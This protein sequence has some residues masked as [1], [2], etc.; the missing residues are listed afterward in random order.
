MNAPSAAPA[1]R[2]VSLDLFRGIIMFLLVAEGTRLYA[3]LSDLGAP[4]SWFAAVMGQ[5]HHHPWNGLWFWDLIQPGFMFIVGVAMAYSLS[6]RRE[7]GDTWNATFRHILYRC[8][9]LLLFGVGLHCGYS[10][11][12]VWELWNV[13]SQLSF[14][15]LVAFLLFRLPV[16]IQFAASIGL[17][18]LTEILYRFAAPAGFDQPFVQGENFGSW[19]D[20][21]LMGKINGGGWVAVNALPTAVH[22]IWGVL[23]GLLLRGGREHRE[24]LQW[25]VAAGI[26]ALVVGYGM[27]FAGITPIIKRIAT[28][29]FV[30]A[31]GGWV[32]LFLAAAYWLVDVRGVRRIVPFFVVMGMSPIFIYLFSETVGQQWLN[33][34]VHIFTGGALESMGTPAAPAALVT[35]VVVLAIEWALCAWLYRRKIV[36][37]I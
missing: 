6:A 7:R 28:T 36:I 20:M 13:L 26:A 34:F 5:F 4:G 14:T 24:K 8:F 22:T 19:L 23:A 37:K 21:V 2:L 3:N 30:F 18:L 25:L 9:M 35:S 16:R 11:K 1:G 29:S 12:L 33:G 17:L 27:D 31:S 10:G 15:I 32:L